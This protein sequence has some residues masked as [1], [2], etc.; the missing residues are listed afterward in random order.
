MN[1][2][3]IMHMSD[4]HLGLDFP[5]L[6]S[7]SAVRRMEILDA[8]GRLCDMCN[9]LDIDIFLIAGDFLESSSIDG[10]YLE[11]VKRHL[12]R[13]EAEV[14][15][16][17]GNHDYLS[18]DSYY[19]D[20]DFPENVKVFKTNSLEKYSIER[21]KTN[22]YG[23]SFT[24]YYQREGFLS[25]GVVDLDP[26][27]INICLVHGDLG[28]ND[29]LYNP[30][31]M[32]DFEEKGF[33]YLALGHIHKTSPIGQI[34]TGNYAYPGSFQALSFG[35]Q[36]KNSVIVCSLSKGKKEFGYLEVKG[37]RLVNLDFDVSGYETN[38]QLAED[39]RKRLKEDFNSQEY[40]YLDNYYRVKLVGR[41]NRDLSIDSGVIGNR[42]KDLKYL[43]L[44]D[45]SS[46]DINLELEAKQN[47]LYGLVIR[48]YLDEKERLEKEGRSR[49]I[50]IL[51]RSLDLTLKAFEGR[52]L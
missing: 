51:D 16:V 5:F 17:A 50:K 4:S 22:I 19:L 7:L 15:L 26:D 33:D 24:S 29:S 18:L 31:S 8:F 30:I 32:K 25:K 35:D 6:G 47:N 1:S 52:K 2:I 37:P 34:K 28:K 23:A 38:Y 44:V 36:G 39:L 10:P 20:D 11:E 42:L 3:K 27:Y 43:D 40:S 14:V 48:N 12:A 21:L 41:A 9:Q 49:D 46:K 45:D 13:L